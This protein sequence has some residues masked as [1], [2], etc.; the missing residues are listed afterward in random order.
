MQ[1]MHTYNDSCLCLSS[2]FHGQ[3]D[4]ME[5][6]SQPQLWQKTSGFRG[7]TQQLR[8]ELR[9]VVDQGARAIIVCE[10]PSLSLLCVA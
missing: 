10:P 3:L 8:D 5:R 2:I 1:V 9:V 4:E 6:M 7:C